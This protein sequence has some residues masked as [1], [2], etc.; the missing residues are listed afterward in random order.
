MSQTPLRKQTLIWKNVLLMR[1]HQSAVGS[2]LSFDFFFFFFFNLA[3]ITT[4]Q[5]E[6]CCLYVASTGLLSLVHVITSV[7]LICAMRGKGNESFCFLRSY[8][9]PSEILI[10]QS[11]ADLDVYDH[12]FPV[13]YSS[14]YHPG[15]RHWQP[16]GWCRCVFD[17]PSLVNSL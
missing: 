5:L 12:F 3:L 7:S 1:S 2:V 17:R 15:D 8:N 9:F 16:R 11:E 6:H 14:D 10:K 13:A 4:S